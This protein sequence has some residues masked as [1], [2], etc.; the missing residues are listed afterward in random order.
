[1]LQTSSI[2][3]YVTRGEFM[4]HWDFLFHFH[5]GRF[6]LRASLLTLKFRR[7]SQLS[8]KSNFV[9]ENRVGFSRWLLAT[10]FRLNSANNH[11]PWSDL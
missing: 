3:A 1:V 11:K 6:G 5:S 10:L 2:D 8:H 4:K 7:L 9:S